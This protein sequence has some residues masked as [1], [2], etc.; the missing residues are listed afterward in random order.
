MGGARDKD[1]ARL[2]EG[3]WPRKHSSVAEGTGCNRA[4]AMVVGAALELVGGG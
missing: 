4:A 2:N 1:V 3:R